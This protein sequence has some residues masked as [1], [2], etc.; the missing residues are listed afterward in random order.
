MF[1]WLFQ[2]S[3]IKKLDSYLYGKIPVNNK[4]KYM[5]YTSLDYSN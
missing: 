5:F 1:V 2:T 4:R 3:V